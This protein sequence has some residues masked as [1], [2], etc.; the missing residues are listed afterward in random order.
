MQVITNIANQPTKDETINENKILIP[1]FHE[2]PLQLREEMSRDQDYDDR[3]ADLCLTEKMDVDE[4]CSFLHYSLST[5]H[6]Q[7]GQQV[8]YAVKTNEAKIAAR[9]TRFS[10]EVHHMHNLE[11]YDL[12]ERVIEQKWNVGY[13]K[14]LSG[15]MCAFWVEWVGAELF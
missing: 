12:F 13:L 4:D 7:D 15:D 14:L 5:S 6:H 11:D 8:L 1:T 2:K 3:F 9:R 10:V